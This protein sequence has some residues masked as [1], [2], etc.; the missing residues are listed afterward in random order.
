MISVVRRV[1]DVSVVQL[2]E[3]DEFAKHL[4]D[5]FVDTLKRLK[6]FRH[7]HIG[8]FV[9]NRLHLSQ[10]PKNP[11]LIRVRRKVIAGSSVTS[12]VEKHVG[13]LWS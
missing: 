5:R 8:E 9:M 3:S 11:L 2:I 6:P 12:H 4:F 7:E 1:E 13:I 10:P